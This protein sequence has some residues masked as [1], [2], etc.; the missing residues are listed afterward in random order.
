MRIC[1][2]EDH[3]VSALEP[4]TLC[5]P[6]FDLLCGAR[7]VLQ[8]HRDAFA[9]SET[10]C[11]VRPALADLCRF[12]HPDLIVNETAWLSSKPIIM[13]NARWIPPTTAFHLPQEVHVGM[14]DGQLAY[15]FFS[16]GCLTDCSWD[17]L[18]DALHLWSETLPHTDAGGRMIDYP[19]NLIGW[20][21][22]LLKQDLASVGSRRHPSAEVHI[23]G[24]AD[25]LH[26]DPTACIEPLVAMD[27]TPGPIV[28]ERDVIV[29]SFS[30][31][32]GPCYIG[33]GSWILGARVK[34]STI[35]PVCRIGGEVETSIIQ[36][37]TNK[38][39]EGF[40]GHSY[41]CEWVNFGAGTQTSDLRNDYGTVTMLVAGH[42]IDTGLTKV[43]SFIGDHTKTGL[44]TLLNTGTLAGAFC[45]LLP[46]ETFLPR[47]I[48]SF[49]TCSRGRIENGPD[50][51]RLLTT[52]AKAMQRRGCSPSEPAI[53]F[54]RYLHEQ[55][56]EPRRRAILESERSARR[57]AV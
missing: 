57:R 21:G 24:P 44:N 19:W 35:G 16:A 10:G 17:N 48:P 2:F 27:T 45:N 49:C 43:G 30:R 18:D 28:I 11:I 15:A 22:E 14:T 38:A 51:E 13:V 42:R 6:A 4:L 5:R 39:H 33:P 7:T 36:G 37:Y 12:I 55:T 29:Q 34:G 8:R 31:L 46:G 41:L 52:A 3:A 23:I 56:A 25:R 9:S 54:Y 50:L 40:L 20:N 32:E 26:V 53:A 1:I 47:N